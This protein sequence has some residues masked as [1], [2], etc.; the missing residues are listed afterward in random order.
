[1]TTQSECISGA[2]DGSTFVEKDKKEIIQ[3]RGRRLIACQNRIPVE[4]ATNKNKTNA[5]EK[6]S[7]VNE[8]TLY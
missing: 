6:I 7:R 2:R 5:G 1:M 3:N 8:H 4:R